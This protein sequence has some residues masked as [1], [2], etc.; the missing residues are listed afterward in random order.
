MTIKQNLQLSF[1]VTSLY[2][3]PWKSVTWSK[4]SFL[5]VNSSV[6]SVSWLLR[7]VGKGC[8]CVVKCYTVSALISLWLQRQWIITPIQPV[9]LAALNWFIAILYL[10]LHPSSGAEYCNQ[11]FVCL[12]VCLSVS[13][14]LEPWT[15]FH[16]MFYADPLWPWL[17]P[18]LAALRYVMYFRF[19]GWRHVWP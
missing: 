12:P 15:D 19:Y 7:L 5:V 3:F 11:V 9:E 2:I 4:Q 8:S 13:I 18:P 1:L 6:A 14:S 17:S 16:E 10:L